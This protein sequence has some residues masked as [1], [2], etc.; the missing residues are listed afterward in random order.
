M[1]KSKH[2]L[3]GVEDEEE[4]QKTRKAVDTCVM[5]TTVISYEL[6]LCDVS[7]KHRCTVFKCKWKVM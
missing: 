6:V 7:N 1:F 5:P 2:L 3:R 4:E